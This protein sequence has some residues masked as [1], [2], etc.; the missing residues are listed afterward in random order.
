VTLALLALL[1]TLGASD[2][3]AEGDPRVVLLGF[4]G[5]DARITSKLLESGQ[6][7]NL[8]AIAQ[9]GSFFPL[10]TSNPAQSPVSWACINTGLGP[11]GTNV[12]DFVC[13]LNEDRD[14]R[15]HRK[16]DRPVPGLA[17]AYKASEPADPWLPPLARSDMRT[18]VALALGA[19]ALLLFGV[20]FRL[21]AK[22]PWS[23]ALALSGALGVVIAGAALWATRFLP[24]RLPVPKSEMRGTPFWKPLSDRQVTVEG[25]AV[26]LTFPFAGPDLPGTKILA[27]LG[28]PDARQSWGDWFF[29]TSDS[30]KAA[31]LKETGLMGG[32]PVV[33]E[34]SPGRA[35]HYQAHLEGPENFWLQDRNRAEL[36]EIAARLKTG[37]VGYD[38]SRKLGQR[39]EELEK[40]LSRRPALLVEAKVADDR[41]SVAIELDHRSVV[42]ADGSD[43]LRPGDWSPLTRATLQLNPLL[44]LSVV[45]AF[46]VAAIEPL[47]LFVKP[48]NL[49]PK[50]PPPQASVSS[51]RA[52]SK[53]LAGSVDF[54]TLGWACATN[55]LNDEAI[56]EDAFLEDV[57]R[58]F[59]QRRALLL[60]RIGK[61]DWRLLYD[62]F[63]ETDRVPHMMF[64]HV[65][66]AHPAYSAEG[67]ARLVRFFGKTMPAK[68]TIDEIYRQMDALVGEIV[69][70]VD[71]GKTTVLVVSDHGFASFRRGVHLNNWLAA[72]GY[73]A[74]RTSGGTGTDVTL[75]D[76]V[77]PKNT[78]GYVDWSKTK[79][80]SLGLG[81]IY[82][83]RKGRES[84]GIVPPEEAE[85]L[86]REIAA[87]LEAEIDRDT[88]KPFVKKAYLARDIYPGHERNA[89]GGGR[90]NAEDIVLGFQEG[91]RVSWGTAL[92]GLKPEKADGDGGGDRPAYFI[93]PNTLKW[94]GDHCSVDP[95]FVTGVLFCTR[96]LSTPSDAPAP[97]VRH[98]APTVLRLFGVDP[99]PGMRAPLVSR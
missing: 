92:G 53:E 24:S 19:A 17:L 63:G 85:A 74:L 47:E 11:E 95:S 31:R 45:V 76:L 9:R 33:L 98:V 55:A 2:G 65:D 27:G 72:S 25:L 91:Y 60:E 8:A 26:P 71:D 52:F 93:E 5:V 23:A 20:I 56:G 30:A 49:D 36:A 13:R 40:E 22:Y 58:V 38:E 37:E 70:R 96:P 21:G 62:V 16:I 97:D 83:N 15:A 78:F 43:D 84:T 86:E 50:A 80:Y 88:G 41:K 82:L 94:S 10:R 68:E 12:Y 51:P 67:A 99:L 44:R 69:R 57:E 64:R 81:K 89:D 77:N 7:P 90:D 39:Q 54:E 59:A 1:A 42:R 32:I 87:K 4:D 6:L 48:L 35:D 18:R 79:A 14:D 28:V 75:A 34:R 73:M 29:L 46:R 61:P 3:A 66:P